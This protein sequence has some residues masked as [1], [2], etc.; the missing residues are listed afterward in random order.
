MKARRGTDSGRPDATP[1]PTVARP[2]RRRRNSDG[3]VEH[4]QTALHLDRE[5]NV[6]GRIDDVHPVLAPEAGGRGGGDRDAA[7]LLLLIQSMTAVPSWTSPIVR[8]TPV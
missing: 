1:S 4:P 3:A 6:A 2:R 5:I 7:L 8:E